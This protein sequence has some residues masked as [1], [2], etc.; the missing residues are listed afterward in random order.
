MSICPYLMQDSGVKSRNLG[1][2]AKKAGELVFCWNLFASSGVGYKNLCPRVWRICLEANKR[3]IHISLSLSRHDWYYELPDIK[4]EKPKS[5]V[6][7]ID[8]QMV[9]DVV[10]VLAT[11]QLAGPMEIWIY[12]AKDMGL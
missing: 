7:L 6:R 2:Q 5:D 10:P 1:C 9:E 11:F 8:G 4:V 12:D 3:A